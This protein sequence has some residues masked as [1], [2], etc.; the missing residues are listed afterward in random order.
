MFRDGDPPVATW[1]R[2]LPPA[3]INRLSAGY[4]LATVAAFVVVN[5]IGF[6]TGAGLHTAVGAVMGLAG[7]AAIVVGVL[8]FDPRPRRPWSLSHAPLDATSFP[9]IPSFL[10]LAAYP[11]ITLGFALLVVRR[12]LGAGWAVLLDGGILTAGIA[13]LVWVAFAD[14]I[15]SSN[16]TQLARTVQIVFLLCDIA[17]IGVVS[18]LLLGSETRT[19]AIRLFVLSVVAMLI[20]DGLTG[21]GTVSASS[22]LALLGLFAQYGLWGAAA[23]HP[24][25]AKPARLN[26]DQGHR[27]TAARLMTLVVS[28]L[29]APVL[30]AVQGLAH[31]HIDFEAISLG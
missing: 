18:C 22:P 19:P 7:A 29:T 26:V 3:V 12:P 27:M 9:S 1:L 14:P 5:L 20:G 24:T 8:V 10:Y 11:I 6:V 25:M 16:L 23:L 15:L 21:P 28:G 31:V 2:D 17:L 30:L 4:L 13:L